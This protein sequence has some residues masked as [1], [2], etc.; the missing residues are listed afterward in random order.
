MDGFRW[1]LILIGVAIVAAVY[2]FSIKKRKV[3][4][5]S[6]VNNCPVLSEKDDSSVLFEDP[7]YENSDDAPAEPIEPVIEEIES[8]EQ[9]DVDDLDLANLFNQATFVEESVP[10]EAGDNEVLDGE[11]VS[12]QENN[13]PEHRSEPEPATLPVSPVLV[14]GSIIVLHIK[15]KQKASF[16]GNDV[17]NIMNDY[18]IHYG[19]MDVFHYKND[20]RRVFSILNM[21]EPGVFDIEKMTSQQIKGLTVIMQL[22]KNKDQIQAFN[23]MIKKVGEA[24]DILDATIFDHRHKTLTNQTLDNIRNAISDYVR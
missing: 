10:E 4:D 18:D 5:H 21:V 22:E 2:F 15:P 8:E 16:W 13:S 1:I 3:K 12:P 9:L 6:L 14:N 19:E 20:G 17:L 24:A 11:P 7:V 23:K